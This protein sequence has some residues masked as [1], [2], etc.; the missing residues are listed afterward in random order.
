[1]K[2][3]PFCAEEILDAAI[4]CKHCGSMLDQQRAP[5]VQSPSPSPVHVRTTGGGAGLKAIGTLACIVGVIGLAGG[6]SLGALLLVGGFAIFVVGRF[7][8]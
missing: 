3:C 7:K 2:T 5:Q 8:D 1:M 6:Y 4:K